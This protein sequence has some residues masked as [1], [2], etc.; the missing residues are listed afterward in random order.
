VVTALL[1]AAAVGAGTPLALVAIVAVAVIRPWVF[2]GLCTLWAVVSRLRR[3]RKTTTDEAAVLRAVAAELRAGATVRAAL[4]GAAHVHPELIS[5]GRLAAAGVAFAELG[6]PLCEALP[7][8]G[9]RLAAALTFGSSAGGSVVAAVDRLVHAV[10]ETAQLDHELRAATAQARLSA[11]VVGVAPLVFSAFLFLSGVAAA[12][13]AAGGIAA[14]TAAIGLALQFCGLLV[15]AVMVR[16]R[17][18]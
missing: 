17:G 4:A 2:L 10:V 11:V 1:L 8:T 5:V 16:R 7:E 13:W 9:R 14:T 18:R 15:V 12:P 6:S 3:S